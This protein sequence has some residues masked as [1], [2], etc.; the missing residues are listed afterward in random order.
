MTLVHER[1]S[2]G[3]DFYRLGA[4]SSNATPEHEEKSSG[5]PQAKDQNTRNTAKNAKENGK[6]E[7]DDGQ[8]KTGNREKAMN[9]SQANV[10]GRAEDAG[11]DNEPKSP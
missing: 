6:G 9:E 10:E 3:E 1:D 2:T 5:K 4:A 11:G 8:E 7:D